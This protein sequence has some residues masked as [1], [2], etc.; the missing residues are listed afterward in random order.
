M[1]SHLSLSQRQDPSK[2]LLWCL[3]LQPQVHKALALGLPEPCLWDGQSGQCVSLP[4]VQVLHLFA[5]SHHEY[6]Q[7]LSFVFSAPLAH[8]LLF[9]SVCQKESY[10]EEALQV[11]QSGPKRIGTVCYNSKGN[12]AYIMKPPSN[13]LINTSLFFE[14]NDPLLNS[15]DYTT[16]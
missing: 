13:R 16:F 3:C 8:S 4:S 2:K 6:S 9:N 5:F 1:E 14:E 15:V 12:E 10:Q 11:N 7:V